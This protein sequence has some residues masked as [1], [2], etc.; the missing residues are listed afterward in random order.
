MKPF[1]P[2][3][4][5]KMFANYMTDEGIISNMYKQFI[6]LNIQFIQLNIKQTTTQ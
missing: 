3:E 2:T 6:L 5:E 1:L 4:W